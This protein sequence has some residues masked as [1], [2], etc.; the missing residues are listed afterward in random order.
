MKLSK[1]EQRVLSAWR[2]K[3]DAAWD[4]DIARAAQ[5]AADDDTPQ[6]DAR[7]YRDQV[8]EMRELKKAGASHADRIGEFGYVRTRCICDQQ[9]THP[10]CRMCGRMR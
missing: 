2:E 4:K 3:N 8:R 1:D 10:N 5:I 7:D 6:G 9:W